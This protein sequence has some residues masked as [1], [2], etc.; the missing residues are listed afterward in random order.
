MK[1]RIASMTG[2][3]ILATR[4]ILQAPV[5]IHKE[6]EYKMLGF[7]P[8]FKDFDPLKSIS[9]TKM[10]TA[11]HLNYGAKSPVSKRP[12]EPVPENE[13]VGKIWA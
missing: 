8:P 5:S 12:I 7:R 13:K 11:I 3:Q 10:E 9:T 1:S 6:E 2:R 4:E